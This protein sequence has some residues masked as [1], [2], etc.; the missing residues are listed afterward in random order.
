MSTD[1]KYAVR[2]Q[3]GRFREGLDGRPVSLEG[4]IRNE[5]QNDPQHKGDTPDQVIRKYNI[6]RD[7][8][9]EMKQRHDG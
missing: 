9:K 4:R 2:N 1:L 7:R 6:C 8:R 5:I 3:S